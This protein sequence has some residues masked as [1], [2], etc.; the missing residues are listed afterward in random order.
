MTTSTNIY[1]S[2][3]MPIEQRVAYSNFIN[4]T[5]T[6]FVPE[7]VLQLGDPTPKLYLEYGIEAL[8]TE[9]DYG[10]ALTQNFYNKTLYFGTATVIPAIDNTGVYQYDAVY[11]E[12]IDPLDN[13]NINVS[14]PYSTSTYHPSSIEIMRS[15][16][17]SLPGNL[18]GSTIQTGLIEPSHIQTAKRT[19]KFPFNGIILCHAYPEMGG[20]IISRIK[21]HMKK[22]GFTF[23]QFNFTV[24]RLVIEN[25][26]SNTGSSYLLFPRRTI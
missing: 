20:R 14:V 24:D 9:A 16:L 3:L 1:I 2:P 6:I 12:L 17:E 26:L 18:A 22:N 25:T 5:S 8:T 15:R 11:V 21:K 23:N 10:P 19:K 4:N 13:V 7:Y